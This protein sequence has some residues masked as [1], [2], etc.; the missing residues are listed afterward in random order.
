MYKHNGNK[1]E[2]GEA[3]KVCVSRFLLFSAT[4]T[5]SAYLLL[6]PTKKVKCTLAHTLTRGNLAKSASI[7]LQQQHQIRLRV[8]LC[9]W[10]RKEEN[11]K[12]EREKEKIRDA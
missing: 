6:T 12:N 3:A 5:S 1:V 8:L 2:K 4:V 11:D 7:T 9:I 10:K